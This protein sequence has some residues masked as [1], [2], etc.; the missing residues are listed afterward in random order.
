[1]AYRN[2]LAFVAARFISGGALCAIIVS[3]VGACVRP[4]EE[5]RQV[6]G[7]QESEWRRQVQDLRSKDVSLASRLKVVSI[8]AAGGSAEANLTA[9]RLRAVLNGVDQS[10]ADIDLQL[11]QTEGRLDGALKAGGNNAL[12]AIDAEDKRMGAL[13]RT[14]NEHLENLVRQM[15]GLDRDTEKTKAA[16]SSATNE[17]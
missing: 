6:L 12:Q 5:A 1:M 17:G 2:R 11:R 13:V 16:V 14:M 4:D 3:P 8:R 10:L 15:D 9:R 7:R